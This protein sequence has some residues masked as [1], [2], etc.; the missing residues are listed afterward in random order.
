[1]RIAE[2]P[3]F[4]RYAARTSGSARPAAVFRLPEMAE[5][6]APQA[7]RAAADTFAAQRR[8]EQR[9]RIVRNGRGLLDALDAVK[10]ALISGDPAAALLALSQ[11]LEQAG[12]RA[13]DPVL[14]EILDHIR[15]RADVELAKAR[16]LA[17]G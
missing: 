15:L 12:E 6:A 11:R 5:A 3:S 9:Q 2:S 8:Q 13:S 4:A 14:D 7:A 16:K 1:M 17:G 10:L